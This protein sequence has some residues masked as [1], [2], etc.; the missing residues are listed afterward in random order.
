MEVGKTNDLL[1]EHLRWIGLLGGVS[2]RAA[3]CYRRLEGGLK[4]GLNITEQPWV[5]V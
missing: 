5:L 3:H 4:L 1:Q 2:C